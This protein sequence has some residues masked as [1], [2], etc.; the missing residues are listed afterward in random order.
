MQKDTMGHKALPL[1]RQF[2]LPGP[3]GPLPVI[4]TYGATEAA[5]KRVF[6][7]AHGFRGSMDGGGRAVDMARD[8]SP[9]CTVVRFAFSWYTLLTNQIA[10]FQAVVAYVRRTLA[11]QKL[12][13]LGR[14]LGGATAILAACSDPACVPDGLI[15]WSAPNNLQRTFVQVLTQPVFDELR[16]GRDLYLEDEKGR[17]LIRGTF[18]QDIFRYDL[19]ACL[20]RWPGGPVLLLH[21]LADPVVS[22]D[23]AQANYDC[24]PGPKELVLIEGGDHSFAR[25]GEEAG[26]A[27]RYWLASLLGETDGASVR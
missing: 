14:S 16:A 8:L 17:D 20:K 25:K 22:W 13:C 9:L 12:Y 10:E 24:L 11:P 18:V 27:A 23:Q 15:L 3:W 4:I 6:V 19:P 26:W 1:D 2:Y 21:G 5:R 7:M